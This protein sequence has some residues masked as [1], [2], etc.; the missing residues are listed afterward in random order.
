[1]DGE[2]QKVHAEDLK[3]EDLILVRSGAPPVDG[4]VTDGEKLCR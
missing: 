4:P 2:A 3:M 1:M